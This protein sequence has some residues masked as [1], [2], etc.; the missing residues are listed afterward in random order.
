MVRSA[1][2]GGHL[3]VA[4]FRDMKICG[5]ALWYGPGQEAFETYVYHDSIS[6]GQCSLFLTPREEQLAGVS[7]LFRKMPADL[8]KWWTEYVEWMLRILIF[9]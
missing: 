3:L 4:S 9:R 7:A 2:I 1:A 8:Y 6:P 5:V